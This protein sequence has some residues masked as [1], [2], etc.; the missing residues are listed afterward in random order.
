MSRWQ[1]NALILSCVWAVGI[2]IFLRYQELPKAQEYA[3]QRYYICAQL[4]SVPAGGNND[5]CLKNVEKDWDTWMN[6]KWGRIITIA[7][8]PVV[9]GWLAA[10]AGIFAWRRIRPD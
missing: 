1:Q 7:L 6:R 3:T 10:F 5:T 9:I 4:M 2:T 8:L